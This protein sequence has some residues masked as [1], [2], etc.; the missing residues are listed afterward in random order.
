[1]ENAVH[2]VAVENAVRESARLENAVRDLARHGKCA[3]KFA[4]SRRCGAGLPTALSLEYF[5]WRPL[6]E[7]GPASALHL[8]C[9]S[10]AELAGVATSPRR[11]GRC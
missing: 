10:N 4:R 2:N 11:A 3:A 1:M 6:E 9:R 7:G 8:L 5:L